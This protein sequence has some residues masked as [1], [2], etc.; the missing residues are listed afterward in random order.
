M[1]LLTLGCFGQTLEKDEVDEFTGRK[2]K[3]TSVEVLT[4]NMRFSLF[5]RIMSEDNKKVV[6]IKMMIGA[7]VFSIAEGDEIMFK[8]AGGQVVTLPCLAFVVTCTGCGAR[9]FGGSTGQGIN[10]QYFLSRENFEL[11]RTNDLEK[12]RVYTSLGYAEAD[13]AKG[14]AETFRRSFVILD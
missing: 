14:N 6:N 10:A 4:K 9:G 5:Y 11:L 8:M 3:H 13:I 1:A 12:I 2:V 7:K